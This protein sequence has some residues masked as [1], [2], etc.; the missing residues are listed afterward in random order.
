MNRDQALTVLNGLLNA[1][2]LRLTLS[3]QELGACDLAIRT[4]ADLSQPP[5]AP[6]KDKEPGT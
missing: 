4:L 1:P 5:A 6:E 2:A 3:I